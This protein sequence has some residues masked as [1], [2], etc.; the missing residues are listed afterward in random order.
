[1]CVCVY[2]CVCCLRVCL[3]WFLLCLGS[4]PRAHVLEVAARP[5]CMQFSGIYCSR[6]PVCVRTFAH[7][8]LPKRAVCSR[9]CACGVCSGAHKLLPGA[10]E[11]RPALPR[12]APGFGFAYLFDHAAAVITCHARG[13]HGLVWLLFTSTAL[14][15]SGAALLGLGMSTEGLS[16][17]QSRWLD[18]SFCVLTCR[19][20]KGCRR[21]SFRVSGQPGLP[22]CN[23]QVINTGCCVCGSTAAVLFCLDH[24]AV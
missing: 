5:C 21:Q 24:H 18:P 16:A 15:P 13:G 4:A 3:P 8:S 9:H 11:C 2:H 14:R 20:C 7:A 12:P 10:M 1:V 23:Q 22:V 17:V 6:P 19:S